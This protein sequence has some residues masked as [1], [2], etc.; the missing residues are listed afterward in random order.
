MYT[1]VMKVVAA[2]VVLIQAV[3]ARQY[4]WVA[5]FLLVALMFNPAV[6]VF[7]LTGAA[8]LSLVVLSVAPFVVLLFALRPA[9]VMSIPS[10]TDRNPGSQSL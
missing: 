3:Q 9:P 10:I 6:P 1:K 4:I 2:T 8:A 5:G 7:R